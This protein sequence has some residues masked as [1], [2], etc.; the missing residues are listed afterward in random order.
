MNIEF[1]K[2]VLKRD[3][4]DLTE[5]ASIIEPGYVLSRMEVQ[6]IQSMISNIAIEVDELMSMTEHVSQKNDTAIVSKLDNSHVEKPDLFQ[7]KTQ[8]FDVLAKENKKESIEKKSQA[9]SDT[10]VKPKINTKPEPLNV[11]SS[12]IIESQPLEQDDVVEDQTVIDVIQETQSVKDLKEVEDTKSNNV[13]NVDKKAAKKTLA[14]NFA[15]TG[16]S[17]NESVGQS[18][19]NPD[20]ASIL[21]RKPISDIHKAVSLNERIAFIRQLF[22][23]DAKKYT[24]TVDVLNSIGD[25]SK[26]LEFINQEFEWDQSSENVKSFIEIVDRRYLN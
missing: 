18:G 1:L 26:A 2:N 23:G 8:K 19:I 7:A 17:L 10:L 6:I 4:A 5:I 24:Q 22:N 14:D 9:K 15:D 20:R 12:Q 21:S 16:V 25:F 13:Q 3:I 11:D